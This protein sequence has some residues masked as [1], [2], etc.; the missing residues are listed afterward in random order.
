MSA[1]H[2]L[3]RPTA[4]VLRDIIERDGVHPWPEI[5]SGMVVDQCER[6]SYAYSDRFFADHIDHVILFCKDH[7]FLAVQTEDAGILIF[8]PT[9]RQFYPEFA[10]SYFLATPQE[11]EAELV[12]HGGSQAF[13]YTSSKGQDFTQGDSFFNAEIVQQMSNHLGYDALRIA[14][15][16]REWE[17]GLRPLSATLELPG[18]VDY[19][20]NS[21]RSSRDVSP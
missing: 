10:E 17:D 7:V 19:V 6:Y 16:G 14:R 20:A 2:T 18:W 5:Q 12:K 4:A 1:S 11:L 3:Y 9:Y 13:L 15:Y 8:D 21:A